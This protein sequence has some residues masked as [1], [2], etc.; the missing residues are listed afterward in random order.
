MCLHVVVLKKLFIIR[1]VCV[2][3]QGTY[4]WAGGGS[5][6]QVVDLCGWCQKLHSCVV[7]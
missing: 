4:V 6:C 7:T 3:C 2:A 1:G 5:V